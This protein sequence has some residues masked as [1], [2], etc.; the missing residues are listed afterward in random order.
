MCSSKLKQA[1]EERRAK[2]EAFVKYAKQVAKRL[3]LADRKS[4]TFT[5]NLLRQQRKD[6]GAQDDNEDDDSQSKK[7]KEPEKFGAEAY[8]REVLAIAGDLIRESAK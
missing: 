4:I 2:D 1:S 3:E 8:T 6:V 7:K 5:E